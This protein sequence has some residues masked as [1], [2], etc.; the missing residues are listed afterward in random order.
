MQ[1]SRFRS[2]IERTGGLALALSLCA[3]GV[4]AGCGDDPA[5]PPDAPACGPGDAPV[6]GIET[7]TGIELM[8]GDLV[9]GIN[10]DCPSAGTPSGI[11]SMTIL[12]KRVGG[13]GLI[14]LCVSRPDLLTTAPQN[15]VNDVPGSNEV[16]LI[17]L[18]ATVDGCDYAVDQSK[19]VFGSV[20][21]TGLCGN[22]S[23]AAGFALSISGGASLTRQC[24]DTVDTVEIAV[25]GDVAVAAQ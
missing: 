25:R 22:G 11:I 5:P 23:D 14:T 16:L 24:G 19:D 9:A 13:A 17:D 2:S 4:I 6:A 18:S 20:I 21:A 10:N 1:L 3:A 8:Y 12:G 15:L 7:L